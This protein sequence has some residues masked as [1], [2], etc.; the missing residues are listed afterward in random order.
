MARI[1]ITG[2][3]DGLGLMAAQRL[4]NDGHKVVAHARNSERADHTRKSLPEAESVVVGDFAV[5]ADMHAVVTQASGH[6]DAVIHNAGV[7]NLPSRSVTADGLELTFAV[8]VLAP[9]VLTATMPK[10]ARLIYL[11]SGLHRSGSPALD[12]PQWEKRRF[13][14]MQ[15]YCDSK[16]A[17]AALA[18]A[19]AR[20]YPKVL[21]SVVEPGWVATKMG[22]AGATDDLALGSLTQAWLAVTDDAAAKRSPSYLFHQKPRDT[23]NAVT[24]V[25]FQEA[26]LAH[27]KSVS[28]ATL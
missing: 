12:D 9:Y 6:F 25:A 5:L 4:L 7:Y 24:D 26:L 19:G 3:S 11:S 20:L 16:L 23:H 17:V 27:C 22:G 10:P 13:D 18:Y 21:W 2:S 15:A 8:N 14:G 1:F 28:G